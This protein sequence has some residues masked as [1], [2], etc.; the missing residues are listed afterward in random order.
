[1]VL[2]HPLRR[3]ATAGFPADTKII[4]RMG[5]LAARRRYLTDPGTPT[6]W[7]INH[8]P[9]RQHVTMERLRRLGGQPGSYILMRHRARLRA[10]LTHY[11][12]S[13]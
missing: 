6:A 3:D 10:H 9:G 8:A 1:M 4:D 7:I 11:P 5:I 12:A 2:P 13:A